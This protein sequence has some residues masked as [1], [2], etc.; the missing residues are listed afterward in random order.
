MDAFERKNRKE[1]M[2][3]LRFS[4]QEEFERNT[5][6]NLQDISQEERLVTNDEGDK[7]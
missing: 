6:R 1:F 2:P 7:L 5:A 4:S 3:E